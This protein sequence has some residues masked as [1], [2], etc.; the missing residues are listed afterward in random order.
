MPHTN[1]DAPATPQTLCEPLLLPLDLNILPLGQNNYLPIEKKFS[2]ASPKRISQFSSHTGAS[3]SSPPSTPR[4]LPGPDQT[5]ASGEGVPAINATKKRRQQVHHEHLSR[6]S[7]HTISHLSSS[8][9]HPRSAPF[10]LKPCKLSRVSPFTRPEQQSDFPGSLPEGKGY[11][12]QGWT[13]V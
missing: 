4:H 12:H 8:L 9:D 5:W 10:L 11:A 13:H 1:V 6:E 7:R 2:R 3:P